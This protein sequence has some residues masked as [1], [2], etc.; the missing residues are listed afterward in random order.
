MGARRQGISAGKVRAARK[1]CS[2]VAM[3][4]GKMR[5]ARKEQS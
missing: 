3:F 4:A 5:A 1:E 2:S